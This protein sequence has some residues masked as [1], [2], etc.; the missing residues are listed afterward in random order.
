MFKREPPRTTAIVRV[1]ERLHASAQRIAATIDGARSGDVLEFA[2]ET[3]QEL[4]ARIEAAGRS[5]D[6]MS[7]NSTELARLLVD[8]YSLV[9][10]ERVG[11][12]MPTEPH[13]GDRRSADSDTNKSRIE[14]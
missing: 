11:A 13:D 10:A 14:A 3:L 12:T 4:L 2:F 1:P 8:H 6:M 5:P 9:V 7:G